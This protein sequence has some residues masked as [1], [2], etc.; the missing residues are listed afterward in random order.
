MDSQK[1]NLHHQNLNNSIKLKKESST[2][3]LITS[4]QLNKI[5]NEKNLMSNE[6]Y[7]NFFFGKEPGFLKLEKIDKSLIKTATMKRKRRENSKKKI[8]NNAFKLFQEEYKKTNP[9]LSNEEFIKNTKE[10]WKQMSSSLRN[11]YFS[12]IEDKN[13]KEN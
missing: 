4:I 8:E 1:N 2:Q 13:T 7:F 10:K 3:T 5:S 6:D 12:N 11:I 9:N